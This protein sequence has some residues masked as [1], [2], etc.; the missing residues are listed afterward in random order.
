MN[1]GENI[2][3]LKGLNLHFY[4]DLDLPGVE[5][6]TKKL[7]E[8]EIFN[9][10]I[11]EQEKIKYS[12]FYW[13]TNILIDGENKDFRD[14]EKEQGAL[15]KDLIDREKEPF[16][17]FLKSLSPSSK[18]DLWNKIKLSNWKPKSRTPKPKG[19]DWI[20]FHKDNHTHEKYSKFI[21][22]YTY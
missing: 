15:L 13:S 2:S 17:S 20:D 18:K 6:L 1:I 10:T 7:L 19:Y 12:V 14:Y 5:G 22:Q 4:P 9:K 11:S 8:I 16:A 21:S 3:K